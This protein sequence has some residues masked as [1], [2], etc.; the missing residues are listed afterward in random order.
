[1]SNAPGSPLGPSNS[2]VII[3]PLDVAGDSRVEKIIACVSALWEE[4]VEA[5]LE[6]EMWSSASGT[7]GRASSSC[8][9][10]T[11]FAGTS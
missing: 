7:S 1:M 11:R 4:E 6:K 10:S 5:L 2:R 9:A 8:A 3:R